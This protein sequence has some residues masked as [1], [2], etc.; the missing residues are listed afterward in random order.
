VLLVDM[1]KG[2]LS[3]PANSS[4]LLED[5]VLEEVEEAEVGGVGGL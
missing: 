3:Y 5:E 1:G 2:T 4:I